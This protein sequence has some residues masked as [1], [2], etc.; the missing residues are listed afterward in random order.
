MESQAQL[1]SCPWRRR[2]MLTLIA[3]CI[4]QVN[5]HGLPS[6]SRSRMAADSSIMAKEYRGLNAVAPR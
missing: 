6:H 3:F 4:T 2:L 1:E 5:G